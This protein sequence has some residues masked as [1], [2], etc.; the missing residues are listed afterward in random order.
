MHSKR[1]HLCPNFIPAPSPPPSSVFLPT[2]FKRLDK[3]PV[4]AWKDPPLH[5]GNTTASKG[6]ANSQK[7]V[8][9]YIWIQ[10]SSNPP[11]SLYFLLSGLA[12]LLKTIHLSMLPT[13]L[14][15]P[16]K[17]NRDH[18]S[19]HLLYEQMMKIDLALSMPLSRLVLKPPPNYFRSNYHWQYC[20]NSYLNYQWTYPWDH[21]SYWNYCR[22][23]LV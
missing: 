13:V 14:V 6:R 8:T 4:Q 11:S 10:T 18:V 5:Q 22:N 15:S 16:S 19:L 1:L 20:W 7:S 9:E 2:S 12:F 17:H 23:T 21:G 3:I